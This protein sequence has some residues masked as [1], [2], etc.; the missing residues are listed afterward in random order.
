MTPHDD[1]TDVTERDRTADD[2]PEPD[3]DR[4]VRYEKAG[5]VVICD[6]FETRGWVRSDTVEP[7]RR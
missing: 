6:R 7:V 1:P 2:P 3:L 5:D 4:Y